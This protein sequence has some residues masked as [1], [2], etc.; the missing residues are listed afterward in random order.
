MTDVN[1]QVQG[2]THVGMVRSVNQ[3]SYFIDKSKKVYIVAD[4]MGG[5]AG[6]EVASKMCTEKVFEYLEKKLFADEQDS[7]STDGIIGRRLAEAI[8]YSSTAIFEKSL[9]NPALKGMGTT[10]TAI[11]IDQNDGYVA[12]VGD[13]RLYLIRCGYIYQLTEDHSFVTEQLKAGLITEEEAEIHKMK[14]I[15]TRSVG[16]QEEEEVDT[17]HF[18]LIKDDY[19]LICSDGLHGKVSCSEIAEIVVKEGTASVNSLIDLA[20]K[21]G[22]EDNIT[23]VVL[24]VTGN[25]EAS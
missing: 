15:I 22:G 13:S 19:I 1:I 11:I 16:Y 18:K 8:N 12:H 24:K 7:Q 2:A 3:D 14:N 6:G 21:N 20:N 9:E 17:H 4:G 23:A 25:G 10:S 5:H